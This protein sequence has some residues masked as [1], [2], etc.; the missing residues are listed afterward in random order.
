MNGEQFQRFASKARLP[1]K[2]TLD[3][4]SDTVARFGEVWRDSSPLAIP[5]RVRQAIER[6]LPT[7]PLWTEVHSKH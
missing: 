5:D 1:M 2:L 3:T 7:V 6:H 4:M